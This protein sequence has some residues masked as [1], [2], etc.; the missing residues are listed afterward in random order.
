[1]AGGVWHLSGTSRNSC[2]NPAVWRLFVTEIWGA[3]TL[4]LSLQVMY[5]L[6]TNNFF[7]HGNFYI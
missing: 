3:I 7:P 1:M 5:S 6:T 4:L 2:F